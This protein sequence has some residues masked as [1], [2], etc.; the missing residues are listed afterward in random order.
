MRLGCIDIG[1]NTTRLLVADCD[2]T[3]LAAVHQ[4]RV[5]TRI[6][7]ELLD[8]GHLRPVKVAEVATV[9]AEQMRSAHAMG[10]TE[11]H[12]VATEAIRRAGN[13]AEL[14][15][16]ISATAGVAVR[17]LSGEEEARL[18][19][20]GVAGMLPAGLNPG[21]AI[22][23]ADVGGGSSEL[24]VGRPP[25]EVSWWASIPLGSTGLTHALLASD[26]PTPG[27]LQAARERVSL[28]LAG[29]QV[30]PVALAIA[31]GGSATSL[32]RIA[33]PTLD[34]AALRQALD[35]LVCGSGR[36]DRSASRHRHGQSPVAPGRAA[37]AGRRR[38]AVR[39]APARG[40][41]WHS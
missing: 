27:Q 26:P 29:L 25:R 14:L 16:A 6:G 39:R 17:V 22:G 11:V 24:V 30:P 5:F 36:G 40:L 38:R 9:V 37:R 7:H 41:G 10:V 8:H 12:A 15:K 18:A 4:E 32:V 31:V 2:G 13:G 28:G 19:F 33:G 21:R 23:V 35:L 34:A 3:R 1:S 20:L